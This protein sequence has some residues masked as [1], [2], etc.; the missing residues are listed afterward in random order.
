MAKRVRI[1]LT[2]EAAWPPE[3]AELR[4]AAMELRAQ[5]GEQQ[6]EV[7]QELAEQMVDLRLS[8]SMGLAQSLGPIR[9]R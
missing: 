9:S 7:L 4:A 6:L 2:L 5:L 8:D 3:R 1:E